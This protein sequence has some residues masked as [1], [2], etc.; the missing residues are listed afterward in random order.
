MIQTEL[1]LAVLWIVLMLIFL[2][3]DVLRLFSGDTKPGEIEGKKATQPMWLGISMLMLTPILMILVSIFVAQPA[4]RVANIVMAAF[5]FVFN[6]IGIPSYSSAY[7]KFLLAV[8]MV[9]NVMTIV[10][11]WNW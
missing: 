11:A 8:S 6:L 4:S 1:Q 2:L 10:V 7:D 9:V 3:G 5:W